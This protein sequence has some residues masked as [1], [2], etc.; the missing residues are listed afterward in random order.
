MK[1]FLL[2]MIVSAV[3]FNS[4]KFASAQEYFTPLN[5]IARSF[6]KISDSLEKIQKSLENNKCYK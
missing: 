3:L 4:I 2:G 6:E 5:K 1:K